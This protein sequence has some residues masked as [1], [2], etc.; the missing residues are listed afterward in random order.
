MCN[1]FFQWQYLSQTLLPSLWP[2]S[3]PP[4]SQSLAI[5]LAPSSVACRVL[6]A[7]GI[8]TGLYTVLITMAKAEG[9]EEIRGH[10]PL[11]LP[12]L[13]APSPVHS[14]CMDQMGFFCFV[15]FFCFCSVKLLI[16]TSNHLDHSKLMSFT[17]SQRVVKPS[18][19]TSFLVHALYLHISF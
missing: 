7:R 10:Q 16:S 11:W 18:S 2:L 4:G 3:I 12:P 6:F 9:M 8:I 17:S 5:K 15:L 1:Y 19:L 14:V 13:S